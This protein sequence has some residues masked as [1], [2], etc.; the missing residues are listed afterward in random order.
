[1]NALLLLKQN[2]KKNKVNV[3]F[4]VIKRKEQ[5]SRNNCAIAEKTHNDK[6]E[7]QGPHRSYEQHIKLQVVPVPGRLHWQLTVK[8]EDWRYSNF[9][10]VFEHFRAMYVAFRSCSSRNTKSPLNEERNNVYF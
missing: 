5:E 1:M 8:V 3:I 9:H 6:Q 10:V 2:L 7:T 4:T